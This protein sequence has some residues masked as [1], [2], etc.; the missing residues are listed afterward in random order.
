MSTVRAYL[1]SLLSRPAVPLRIVK[2][3]LNNRP[4]LQ[5]DT[6]ESKLSRALDPSKSNGII[7]VT[8]EVVLGSKMIYALILCNRDE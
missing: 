3:E 4:W 8:M 1:G 5:G 7:Q 6:V 2:S